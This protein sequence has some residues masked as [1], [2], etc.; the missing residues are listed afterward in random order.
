MTYL[1]RQILMGL[2]QDLEA[3]IMHVYREANNY[4]DDL[5]KL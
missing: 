1:L 4:A 3:R 2:S 5:T